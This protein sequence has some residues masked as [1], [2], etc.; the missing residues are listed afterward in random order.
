MSR[1][2]SAQPRGGGAELVAVFLVI[3]LVPAAADAEDEAAAGDVVERPRH[4]GE[5]V[6]VAV[7]VRGDE[8]ADLDPLRDFRHRAERGPVV[9][10]GAVRIARTAGRSDPS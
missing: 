1:S 9:E 5:Q 6:R 7:A 3:A 2:R 4:V 10:M 8:A